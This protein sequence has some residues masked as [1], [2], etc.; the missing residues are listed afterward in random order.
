MDSRNLSEGTVQMTLNTNWEGQFGG[1]GEIREGGNKSR[2]EG[3][4][5]EY[6]Q[7]QDK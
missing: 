7:P 6:H 3:R 5:F 1:R 2:G 4:D